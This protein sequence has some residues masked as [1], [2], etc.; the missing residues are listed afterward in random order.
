M[1]QTSHES[2]KPFSLKSK[3]LRSNFH[4]Q[5]KTWRNI[6]TLRKREP[7]SLSSSNRTVKK[8]Q[9]WSKI[10]PTLSYLEDCFLPETGRIWVRKGR[11]WTQGRFNS[12]AQSLEANYWRTNERTKQ[13]SLGWEIVHRSR[14][15]SASDYFVRNKK[16]GLLPQIYDIRV[17]WSLKNFKIYFEAPEDIEF[18]LI[19][20]QAKV[21]HTRFLAKRYRH[22]EKKSKYS[23]ARVRTLYEKEIKC[24]C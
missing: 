10:F 13:V 4:E 21:Q 18:Q 22:D 1:R 15:S 2:R 6:T 17:Q 12:V 5:T 8:N 11:K 19:L 24:N 16:T 7:N 14:F 23:T 20:F 3:I 9:I